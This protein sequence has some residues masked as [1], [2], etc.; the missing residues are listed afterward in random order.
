M[1]N[2]RLYLY[3]PPS[4]LG[5]YLGKRM[6]FG[7]YGAPKELTNKMNRFF[8]EAEDY[9]DDESQDNFVLLNEWNMKDIPIINKMRKLKEEI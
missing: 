1:A 6:A 8:A 4:N 9:S 7:W 5:L 2:S 3:H